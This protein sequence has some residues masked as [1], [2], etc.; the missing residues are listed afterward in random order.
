M[1]FPQKQAI[2][3][4][5]ATLLV[6]SLA[7]FSY[8]HFKRAP[9]IKSSK[10][11]LVLIHNAPG[12]YYVNGA[13]EYAGLEYDLANLFVKDLG[14]DYKVKFIVADH[15]S[16]IL[17]MLKAGKAHFA[18]ANLSITPER[19]KSVKF[20]A[21]Y[22]NV[23][24]HIVY[25]IE[26]GE[27]PKSVDDLLGK[28]IH[29]PAGSSYAERLKVLQKSNPKLTWQEVTSGSTDELIEQ[30]TL[31]F[32]DYTIADNQIIS[33]M[34]NFYPNLG[35]GFA[36]GDP[37]EIAW[38]F[39]KKPDP[40]LY[41]K[42]LDFFKRIKEDGTLKSLV[43]R[44]YGHTERLNQMDVSKYLELTRST[45]PKFTALFKTA[46]ELTEIDWRLLAAISYQESHWDQYNTSPTNVRGMMMLT[47]ET[48][49]ELGVTDRLDAKQS[50]L[51]GARYI[52][53]LKK[54]VPERIPEPDRTWMTLAAYNIGFS[55]LEDARVLA[56]KKGLNP[57][58]WAD[59]KTTLPLLNKAEY[60]RN[61]KFGYANGGAPVI[62]VESIRT[63]FEILEKY[64]PAHQSLLPSFNLGPTYK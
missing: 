7:I 3:L 5:L 25:G 30:V 10:T 9:N 49:D 27:E 35:K 57:D 62:F 38:A 17:P 8:Q 4:A 44:Y 15:I 6:L 58:S 14:D 59:V 54:Q 39:P 64:V 24:Q 11:L 31:G 21:S 26:Q 55:H 46:Q 1:R 19:A 48:A 12:T 34:Q 23:Q 16:Q 36:V 43:D 47:E 13:G 29:I 60:Y 18:A 37:E 20:S 61:A 53:M 40:W 50:I 42:S 33:L 63:Y 32:L 28:H 56:S 52:N 2:Y 41:Q 51:G 22:L 45:L